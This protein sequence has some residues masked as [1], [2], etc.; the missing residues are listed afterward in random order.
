MSANIFDGPGAGEVFKIICRFSCVFH[1]ILIFISLYRTQYFL[2]QSTLSLKVA[3]LG[4]GNAM[5]SIGVQETKAIA[6]LFARRSPAF[7][8]QK[9]AA[10]KGSVPGSNSG[11]GAGRLKL[12][13]IF[14][15]GFYA[16]TKLFLL[17]LLE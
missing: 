3:A 16:W 11:S 12:R 5:G 6:N 15:Y 2:Q 1:F 13:T 4:G 7:S 14:F 8:N 9:G 10:G 17:S